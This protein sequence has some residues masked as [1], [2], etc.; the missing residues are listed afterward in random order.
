VKP[1]V[2]RAVTVEAANLFQNSYPVPADL[3]I[4]FCRNV[5]IYFDAPSRA[6]L[7]NR[8][9]EQLAPG[10]YF[11]IGHTESLLALRHRFRQIRPS[12]FMRPS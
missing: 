11:V 1:A 4:V 6:H 8:L 2:R 12:V 10:G 7:V 3:D 9:F 5:M